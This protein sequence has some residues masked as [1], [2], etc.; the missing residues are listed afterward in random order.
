TD[1]DDADC[2]SYPACAS[3]DII[4]P[5][6]SSF[7]IS[8]TT[9]NTNQIITINWTVLDNE[10]LN[11]VELWR[12]TDLGGVPNASNWARVETKTVSGISDFGSFTDSIPAAGTY[13]YGM[14]VVDNADPENI[15]YEPSPPGEI[16]VIVNSDVV[17][18]DIDEDGYD[19]CNI[20]ETGD[21]GKEIDCDDV[22]PNRY[23][24]NTE[25]CDGLDNDCNSSTLDGSGETAPLNDNQS[26][27]CKN[28]LKI[29]GGIS[30]WI[31]DYST[32]ANNEYPTETF[33]DGFDNNCDGITDE[34]CSCVDNQ[35]QV[36]GS[37][38]G[39]CQKGIQT[40]VSGSWGACVGEITPVAE[41]CDDIKD[42]DCDN[43][44]DCSDADCSADPACASCTDECSIG[45]FGCMGLNSEWT[46]GEAGDG[47]DCLDKVIIAC[48]AG[49]GETCNS[50]SGVC[51]SEGCTDDCTI[52][53]SECVTVDSFHKCGNYD[54]DA[55]ADWGATY[56][57]GLGPIC[58]SGICQA[59]QC[60]AKDKTGVIQCVNGYGGVNC[61]E[62]P[63]YNTA[64]VNYCQIGSLCYSV[65][66]H[67]IKVDDQAVC[68]SC[69]G[70]T[71]LNYIPVEGS[72]HNQSAGFNTTDIT[73]CTGTG[74][75]VVWPCP[76]YDSCADC[77]DCASPTDCTDGL[78]NDGDGD[79]DCDDS[80][81]HIDASCPLVPIVLLPASDNEN[82]AQNSI[83][84][85][86]VQIDFHVN[87]IF[88]Y[89][90]NP[91]G[92]NIKILTLYDDG[93]HS[94][95]AAGDGIYANTWTVAGASAPHFLDLWM[96]TVNGPLSL[97]NVGTFN[98]INPC[99]AEETCC[100]FES[101][102]VNCPYDSF[103]WSHKEIPSAMP[104]GSD[105]WMT[106]VKNQGSCGS[107]WAFATVGSVEGTYNVEQNNPDLDIDLAEKYLVSS[108]FGDTST[109]NCSG[110]DPKK[111]INYIYEEGITPEDCFPYVSPY[112]VDCSN[113][114]SE[115][116]TRLWKI[117]AYGKP[118]SQAITVDKMKIHLT[119]NGP[120]SALMQMLQSGN[121]FVESIF[122]CNPDITPISI[123][124]LDHVVLITGYNDIDKYW[125]VKNSW[126]AGY[127]GNGYFKVGYNEC[128]IEMYISY[129][130]G[131]ISP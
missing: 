99:D 127:D 17:C 116:N 96:S 48:N 56:Y 47:D 82:Y 16:K 88:A 85:V 5:E 14:H 61:D 100:D 107:C 112:E 50:V 102:V 4:P 36:C 109:A 115:W 13:W 11:R 110:G 25:I 87:S 83:F 103:D 114:C 18:F 66:S 9:I 91:D 46:C 130:I 126:G 24:N 19:N 29:C 3:A 70:G 42:N 131:V 37:D 33:C 69:G 89:I 43:N 118:D 20:G 60:Q 44:T 55:C 74:F 79:V 125:V 123:S 28:S 80:D 6:V 31:N 21:D 34:G 49:A 65:G 84:T 1:C 39:A 92:N 106:P 54:A 52:P 23:P 76:A 120:I 30:G 73:Q 32:V 104:A 119:N 59:D 58:A 105:D 95:M 67:F 51:E 40:C 7:S 101:N 86:R 128:G 94:D 121:G 113:R 53:S 111:A 77:D 72:A 64:A 108:C 15:G 124:T 81:C 129:P 71:T 78:D 41:V 45:S 2:S 63:I 26:G 27:V 68:Y 97:D 62:Y 12:T 38:I 75:R 90:Q 10:A 8:P 57:C 35:T 122:K 22:N 98:V 117:G 93:A